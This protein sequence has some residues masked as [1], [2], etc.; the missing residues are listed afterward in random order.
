M[1]GDRLSPL[2]RRLLHQDTF[3]LVVSPAIADLQFEGRGYGA[4][5]IALGGALVRDVGSDV[6]TLCEDG[7]MLAAL[8]AIQTTYFAGMLILMGAL[9]GAEAPAI[10][11]TLLAL[12]S[13]GT[14][15]LFWPQ[16]RRA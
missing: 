10:L 5:W 15:I 3:D 1:R 11:A 4:V 2:A 16:K 12:C 13:A 14:T 9:R 6:R 7:P 8:I